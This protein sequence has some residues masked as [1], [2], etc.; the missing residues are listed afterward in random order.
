MLIAPALVFARQPPKKSYPRHITSF[1][2]KQFSGGVIVVT[3]RF[4]NI[5]DSF[6]FILDTGSGGISL[7]S[8]TCS[9][10]N[11]D[12][13]ATDTTINGI[14]GMRKVH[15]AFDKTLRFPGLTVDK[16]NFH[17]NNYDVLT[18]VYGAKIDGIIG[19]SFFSR[20]VVKINF[21][22]SLVEVYRP[23]KVKYPKGYK[24][25]PQKNIGVP[26]GHAKKMN[27]A[28]KGGGKAKGKG[29]GNGKGKH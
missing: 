25:G 20:Y 26:P 5:K 10:F 3:A 24:G 17:V 9:E 12:T 23:G 16:L 2:F 15:F 6:N 28:P 7:D 27:A 4:E 1:P 21:D 18:S 8:S 13:R 14:G 19:Y 22:S 29:H 11:I